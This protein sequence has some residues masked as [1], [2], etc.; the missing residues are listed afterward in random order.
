[1]L[2]PVARDWPRRDG[3]GGVLR[4]RHRPPRHEPLQCAQTAMLGVAAGVD[5]TAIDT[6]GRRKNIGGGNVHPINAA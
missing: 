6:P 1:M 4:P 3:V 5:E 2:L